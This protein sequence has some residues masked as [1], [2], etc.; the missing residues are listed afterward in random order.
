MCNSDSQGLEFLQRGVGRE[1]VEEADHLGNGG[2]GVKGWKGEIPSCI[3]AVEKKKFT[4]KTA[5]T[6]GK[7]IQ[8]CS[9][10][11]SV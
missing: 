10:Q 6:V 2:E 4:L 11:L 8:A 9:T 1:D 7:P 3:F 5:F